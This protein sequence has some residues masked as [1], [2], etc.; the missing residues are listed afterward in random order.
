MSRAWRRVSQSRGLWWRQHTVILLYCSL[1]PVPVGA[2]RSRLLLAGVSP[3]YMEGGCE[4]LYSEICLGTA[5]TARWPS[6]MARRA[7]D[8]Y[9]YD[10]SPQR[11]S[12]RRHG[13]EPMLWQ[14]RSPSWIEDDLP[15]PPPILSPIR[16]AS[17]ARSGSPSR[18]AWRHRDSPLQHAHNSRTWRPNT[19]W[20]SYENVVGAE[21]L[22]AWE[23][24]DVERWLYAEGLDEAVNAF[25]TAKIKGEDILDL[26]PNNVVT[27][28]NVDDSIA[29]RVCASLLPL[30]SS[31]KRSR[32]IAGLK[33][34]MK[35]ARPTHT[36]L[37][38]DLHIL[39][40]GATYLPPGSSG[41]Y[42][43]VEV[44]DHRIKSGF[45]PAPAPIY[46]EAGWSAY[47]PYPMIESSHPHA[48]THAIAS[49]PQSF[50]LSIDQKSKNEMIAIKEDKIKL[51]CALEA[52]AR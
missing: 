50:R 40:D 44:G 7:A 17:P 29:M 41:A 4:T 6:S 2:T 45:I 8:S 18:R 35:P 43:E 47:S 33:T 37:V 22:H 51:W 34:N 49:E 27:K 46:A 48:A 10:S 28:L 9:L 12:G 26:N 14:T 21:F 1:K 31:W 16:A 25:R 30:K 32:Q 36:K 5:L 20:S 39:V 19:R 15:P 11:W 24:K 52:R 42:I 38:A 13:G 3:P 23:M